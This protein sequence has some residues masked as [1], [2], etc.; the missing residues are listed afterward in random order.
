MENS[1]ENFEITETL[2]SDNWFVIFILFILKIFIF[3]GIVYLCYKYTGLKDEAKITNYIL[4]FIVC[5]LVLYVSTFLNFMFNCYL[6]KVNFSE[7]DYKKYAIS[8]TLAPS[9]ILGYTIFI[10][11]AN[12]LKF[13]PL[14]MLFKI[15]ITS[16]FFII[17]TIGLVYHFTFQI[18]YSLTKCSKK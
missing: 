17:L 10:V 15:F 13:S 6:K 16:P 1:K 3:G 7:M 2:N 12:F 9:I 18:A 5:S 14:G 4:F 11:I 8:S